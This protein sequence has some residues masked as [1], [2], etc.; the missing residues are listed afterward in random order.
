MPYGYRRRGGRFGRRYRS[1]RRS[2]RGRRRPNVGRAVLRG[3]TLAPRHQLLKLKSSFSAQFT[4]PTSQAYSGAAMCI[5]LQN[6]ANPF[7]DLPVGAPLAPLVQDGPT[8]ARGWNAYKNLFTQYCVAGVKIDLAAQVNYDGL[9]H[10]FELITLQ[11]PLAQTDP[12][13][14]PAALNEWSSLPTGTRQ[15][16]SHSSGYP[17]RFKRYI[18][19]NRLFGEVVK[20]HDKYVHLWPLASLNPGGSDWLNGTFTAAIRDNSSSTAAYN[21]RCTISV[22][23]TWYIHAM[24]VNTE[25]DVNGPS[26]FMLKE[27]TEPTFVED[28]LG[29]E[30]KPDL[31]GQQ[32]GMLTGEP[33]NAA[34]AAAAGQIPPVSDS[35]K[36]RM[37]RMI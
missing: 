11:N 31:L 21:L 8:Y 32:D 9:T 1:R 37:Y 36:K 34:G 22:R 20:K 24:S 6:P 18:N 7:R 27:M 19:M 15:V 4:A 25:I 12:P 10:L 28:L 14:L 35:G 2:F 13:A 23:L 33:K 30:N 3:T 17:C 26:A 29:D 5:F 16:I